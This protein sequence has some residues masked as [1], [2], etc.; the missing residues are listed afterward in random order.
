MS[1][2]RTYKLADHLV[3]R[4]T[5]SELKMLF[6][7]Q[8]GVMYELNETAS[9]MVALLNEA[10]RSLDQLVAILLGEYEEQEDVIREDAKQFLSD[11]LHAKLLITVELEPTTQEI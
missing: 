6:D 4:S 10:P 9:R 3:F 7:R 5:N 1:D 11:F 8:Q 2:T